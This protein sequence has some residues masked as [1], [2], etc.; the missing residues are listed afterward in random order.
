MHFCCEH[1][2]CLAPLRFLFCDIRRNSH[3]RSKISNRKKKKKKDEKE[4]QG[5]KKK[6]ETSFLYQNMGKM[7]PAYLRRKKNICT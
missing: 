5:L 1:S 2:Y 7:I 4:I 3:N 6:V